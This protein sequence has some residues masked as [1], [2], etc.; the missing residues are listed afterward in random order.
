MAIVT[1]HTEGC[2][3]SSRAIELPLTYPDQDTGE[4]K[5]VDTVMCG[6][7]GQQI[8]DIQDV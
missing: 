4:N 7:C 3:S 2:S 6:A 1:C 8:T 5:T